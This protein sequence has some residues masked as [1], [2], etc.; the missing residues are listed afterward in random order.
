M[1]CGEDDPCRVKVFLANVFEKEISINVKLLPCLGQSCQNEA[2][3]QLI[4]NNIPQCIYGFN[5]MGR[6][7]VLV[8][9]CSQEMGFSCIH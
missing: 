5:N 3:S 9:E 4:L 1:A 8:F 2:L 6:V 7:G